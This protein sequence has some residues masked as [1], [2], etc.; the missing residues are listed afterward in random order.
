MTPPRGEAGVS[1]NM[2]S[3]CV[4]VSPCKAILP[5]CIASRCRSPIARFIHG[6]PLTNKEHTICAAP[7]GCDARREECRVASRTN[8][9]QRRSAPV[10]AAQMVCSLLVIALGGEPISLGWANALSAQH[11]THKCWAGEASAQPTF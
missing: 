6:K 7:T 5:S 3:A 2:L 9:E 1:D 4:T 8:D 11:F 10:G